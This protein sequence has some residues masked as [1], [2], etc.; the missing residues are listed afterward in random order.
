[1]TQDAFISIQNVDKFF[2]KFQAI[3]DVSIDIG[4][5]EFFSL[6]GCIRLRQDHI[7]AHAGRV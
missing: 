5:A 7:A 4:H 1:M 6:L 2:G 3:D